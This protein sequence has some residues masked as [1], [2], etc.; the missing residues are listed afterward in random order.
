[1]K[2]DDARCRGC[3]QERPTDAPWGLCPSC[4]LRVGLDGAGSGPHE[5]TVTVG[6]AAPGALAELADSLGGLPRVLLRDT[7]PETGPGPIIQPASAEMPAVADRAARLQL[8]G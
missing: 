6:P 8:F 3:G 5:V 4:L 2:N 1:M 7:D